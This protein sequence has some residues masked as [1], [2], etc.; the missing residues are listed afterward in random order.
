ML[1]LGKNAVKPVGECFIRSGQRSPARVGSV[2]P[3]NATVT[4]LAL[5][6]RITGSDQAIRDHG[7]GRPAHG[8]ALRQVRRA[9]AALRDRGKHSILRHGEP[10]IGPLE[11]AMQPDQDADG[12][13]GAAGCLA[14]SYLP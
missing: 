8:Q 12:V 9:H 10:G 6:A 5:P 1:D 3:D 14:H 2:Q 13:N 11:D 7:Q 4:G